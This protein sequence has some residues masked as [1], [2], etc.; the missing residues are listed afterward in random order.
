MR[1]I[2]W[3]VA[4]VV[5][6]AWAA[7]IGTALYV[8]LYEPSEETPSGAA[9][10]ALAGNAAKA[11]GVNGETEARIARAVE[12]YDAGAAPILVVTGGTSGD[13]PSV[14]AAMREYAIANGVPEDAI[15]VEDASRSTLQNALFTADIAE[16]DKTQPIILVSHRYHLPRAQ[17]S[18][19]WAG[20]ESVEVEAADNVT[21][22]LLSEG[23]LWEA[24]KWPLNVA[25]AA[26][27]SAAKAGDVPRES[28]VKYLE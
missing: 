14:A 21:G 26:A 16:L 12:L 7:L 28:Y 20:F 15:L 11:G 9:I 3:I 23:L 27:A 10:V 25:R 8:A 24:L 5:L 6:A 4:I 19:R 13:A 22:F 1:L 17:A 18:F 2:R